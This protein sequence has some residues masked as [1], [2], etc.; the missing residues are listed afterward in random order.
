MSAGWDPLHDELGKIVGC[1]LPPVTFP[2]AV[3][4]AVSGDT[5]CDTDTQ[6]HCLLPIF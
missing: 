4:D 5:L 3:F 2:P 1:R 6:L